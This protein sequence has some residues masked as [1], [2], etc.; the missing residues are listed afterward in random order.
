MCLL[1]ESTYSN[2]NTSI[3]GRF[4]TNKREYAVCVCVCVWRDKNMSILSCV[5]DNCPIERVYE[6]SDIKHESLR[7]A[8]NCMQVNDFFICQQ[9][10]TFHLCKYGMEREDCMTNEEGRCVIS[11]RNTCENRSVERCTITVPSMKRGSK[12]KKKMI[13]E[14]ERISQVLSDKYTGYNFAACIKEMITVKSIEIC[15][16]RLNSIIQRLYELFLREIEGDEKKSQS[17][18]GTRLDS[19]DD[20]FRQLL[21][22]LEQDLT[23]S[24]HHEPYFGHYCNSELGA[25]F[26]T[27]VSFIVAHD[28]SCEENCLVPYT[29]AYDEPI[30]ASR[31]DRILQARHSGHAAGKGQHRRNAGDSQ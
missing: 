1:G 28:L 10:G 13:N 29:S 21:A 16:K 2:K 27:Q 26:R 12:R 11:G 8:F 17:N 20:R 14:R 31:Y 30:Y 25:T 3:K 23:H 18:D 4:D 24:R 22:V 19:C 7:A 15:P 9:H 6:F 5:A